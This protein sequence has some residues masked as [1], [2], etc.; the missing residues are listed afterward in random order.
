MIHPIPKQSSLLAI[1]GAALITTIICVLAT[2]LIIS[3]MAPRAPGF[4]HRGSYEPL[5]QFSPISP[6]ADWS[7]S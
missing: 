5:F 2:S 1:A 6:G 4:E 7:R 3:S